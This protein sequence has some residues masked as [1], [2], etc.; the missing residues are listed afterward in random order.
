MLQRP[1]ILFILTDQMRGDCIS[2]LDHPVVETPYLDALGRSGVVFTKAYSSCPSCIASC[3]SIFTGLSPSSHGRLGYQDQVPW[4]YSQI[5][6]KLLSDAGYDTYCVGKTHFYPQGALLGFQG[7]ESYEGWQNF[8]YTY[9]NDY[10]EWLREHSGGRF[11]EFD[12][13][14]TGNSW[15]ARPSHLPEELHNNS[16][17]VTKSIEFLRN[18]DRRKPFFLNVSFHRPHPPFDPPGVMFDLYR[19]RTLPTV[20]MGDWA[21]IHDVPVDGVEAWH[22]HLPEHLLS[23]ARRAYYAQISHIDLQ[24]GRL[25]GV[26]KREVP[27]GPTWI[28]FSSDHGE[29]L[30]DH[31][32]FRKTYAYEGSARIALMISP[33]DK[34]VGELCDAP[35]ACEDLL[36][37]FE[38]SLAGT[39][40]VLALSAG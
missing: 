38:R 21:R 17:M 3:A 6:P 20:P 27:P 29:M 39:A 16:W 18:W 31:H 19:D 15:L 23:R 8:D 28:I 30:G 1:N 5:L 7:L 35:V 4:R 32:L 13:G 40:R 14:L 25:L 24:I 36:S 9:R 22:G 37:R 11:D 2:L 34:P 26:L 10:L 12:H 33:P